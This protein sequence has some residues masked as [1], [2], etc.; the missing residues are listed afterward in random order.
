MGIFRRPRD[1]SAS[2]LPAITEFWE[3]WAQARPTI[4]ASLAAGP[5]TEA[6]GPDPS[7]AD[8]SGADP[9]DLGSLDL[10]PL[11]LGSLDPD[12]PGPG[13]PGELDAPGGGLSADAVDELSRRVHKIHPELQWEIGGAED[14]APTLTVTGG[15]DPEL[16]GLSERWFRAAPAGAA[17]GGWRFHPARQADPEMLAQDLLLG[18]HEFDLEYVRL[19]MRADTDR[20]RV[21]IGAYH[22]DFLFVAEEQQLQVAMHVLDWALGEDDVAR[23]VG[24]VTIATEA[25]IDSL[26]PALLASVVEQ[27][28]EPFEEPEW[29]TGE[30]RTPRGHP[31]RL[32][33][34]FPLHRQDYPLCDLHVAIT[35]PYA[36]SNPD[37]LPVEPSAGALRAFEKKLTKLGDK[38]V[39]AVRETGDGLRVFHLYADPDSGVIGDLDQLAAGWSEGKAKVASTADPGWRVLSAYLP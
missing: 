38:A 13:A 31:A 21:D 8:P 7:G 10:G 18:D 33:A 5:G 27:I 23:W 1:A 19:G 28:A 24:E 29:L 6:P 34:R 32:G 16:R 36:H 2:T 25:P 20:A 35:V 39:L 9:L 11:D 4:E 37:R 30:G 14:R 12:R 22:P 15:G 26:P 3:W 17:A